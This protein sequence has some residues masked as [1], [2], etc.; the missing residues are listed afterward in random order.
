MAEEI[1]GINTALGELNTYVDGAFKDGIISEAEAKAIKSYLMTL[2]SKKI[3][4]DREYSDLYGNVYINAE[5]IGI[6]ES[7]KDL[8][9]Q[10][11]I[12]LVNA[13]VDSIADGVS[14]IT[15]TTLVKQAFTNYKN[16]LSLL[17]SAL[18]TAIHQ[19]AQA[20]VDESDSELREH[21]AGTIAPISEK[22]TAMET[23]V[24]QT[25]ED[26]TFLATKE[27]VTTQFGLAKSGAVA[28]AKTYADG[29]KADTDADLETLNTALTDI[30]S[31][32]DGAFK[33]GLVTALEASTI[34]AY[35][36]QL[37]TMRATY[38]ARYQQ[39]Y[40][41]TYL[42]TALVKTNLSQSKTDYESK[43]TLLVDSIRNAV[44]DDEVSMEEKS[45]VDNKFLDY[46]NSIKVLALRLED[47]IDDIAKNK[48]LEAEGNAN[49]YTD[50]E[51]VP[52]KET[53]SQHSAEIKVNAEQL[54]LKVSTETYDKG[55]GDL[56]KYTK[57]IKSQI[58]SE[59]AVLEQG[60]L[61]TRNL[62]NTYFAD[63]IVYEAEKKK[64][65]EFL[66]SVA[67]Y[68]LKVDAKYNEVYG[69]IWLLGTQKTNLS[70]SKTNADN[71]HTALATV[72]TDAIADGLAS[73]L[74]A[75]SVGTAFTE[76]SSAI[77]LLSSELIKSVDS[78]TNAKVSDAT[79]TANEYGDGLKAQI[80][81]VKADLDSDLLAVQTYVDT[82]FSDGYITTLESDTLDSYIVTLQASKT[83]YD[84]L[85]AQLYADPDLEG[86]PK[87][88]L[89]SAKS[90]YNTK[91]NT[92][93]SS[94]NSAKTDGAVSTL[95]VVAVDSAFSEY[96]YA[97]ST[98]NTSLDKAI[99]SLT[100]TKSL[101]AQAD[102]ELY[103]D[104]AVDPLATRLR[105]AEASISLLDDEIALRVGEEV[106]SKI[107]ESMQNLNVVGRNL[108]YNSTFM[109]DFEGWTGVT[110]DFTIIYPELESDK[111][112]SRAVSRSASGL[113][114]NANKQIW[115]KPYEVNANG[116]QQ[117]TISFD[118]KV[119]SLAA[120]DTDNVV[121]VVRTFDDPD[122]TSQADSVWFVNIYKSKIVKAGLK[123]NTWMR[124][125][126][127]I[128][129]LAGKY[130]K[131]A[132]YLARNGEVFWK[133]I[134]L[135]AGNK[136][137]AWTP[138]L[139]DTD[140]VIYN[141]EKTVSEAMLKI[142]PESIIGTVISS[143]EYTDSLDGKADA[144]K[145]AG[146]ATTADIETAM[147]DLST[148]IGNN[149]INYNSQLAILASQVTQTAEDYKIAF[150]NGGG[151][152][153]LM[154]SV[155][156]KGTDF[157]TVTGSVN[158]YQ[159]IELDV[160]GSR[161]A[162]ILTGGTLTQQIAVIPGSYILSTVVKKEATGA[163][164]ITVIGADSGTV[165]RDFVA[166]TEYVYEK[167]EIPI[168]TQGN[169]IEIQLYG[170]A[171][172]NII[173]TSTMVNEGLVALKW[174][175]HAT[176][177]YNTNI[178]LDINGIKVISTEYDGYTNIT[179]KEFSGYAR[180]DGEMKRVFTLN[181]DVTEMN[182]VKVEGEINMPPVV[183]RAI[184]T[185]QYKGWAFL[186]SD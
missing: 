65:E 31:Y 122:K 39:I 17:V 134:K 91:F 150:A 88:K 22:V 70:T 176:E 72:I 153:L 75:D 180:V 25:A 119:T 41:N 3:E 147:L 149:D 166:G 137:Y 140:Q 8:Y 109:K 100:L 4:L 148:I 38:D 77:A 105:M 90:S 185:Q 45:D 97:D 183:V 62:I 37:D 138:A 59:V 142:R 94:I 14:D 157:W 107:D 29:L 40:A 124:Y 47:A 154:N 7:A 28:D 133:E 44:L 181:K 73:G 173:F 36:K 127:V 125:S 116:T 101:K 182:R 33:D 66:A 43:Y 145:L 120:M 6:M 165:V 51:L 21:V 136:D 69:N 111:T 1:A 160:R 164:S 74:E 84:E 129:P 151:V 184:N 19:I 118:I 175:N 121:F 60:V 113:V 135:G 158:T 110:T 16:A 98:L 126:T 161:S 170:D 71:K 128:K 46:D 67:S 177:L 78:I 155:G 99:D 35:I 49:D 30:D 24:N 42:K 76:F 131:V 56:E 83:T 58:K 146:L 26:I 55:V 9:D 172:S 139:E 169:I 152:N 13:I 108:V 114:A 68:K 63:G 186:P 61:D 64:V 96:Q 93:I 87:A 168:V 163:G 81:P 48:A 132:P 79:D 102:A 20:K 174:S 112:T 82:S 103:A 141:L 171:T 85:Y 179:P 10:A 159:G 2:E 123:D 27:E 130:I 12:Q 89:D 143:K 32:V 92:V 34:E 115:S 156:F 95:E 80:A 5:S 23:T 104:G 15:E 57:G 178:L 54:L 52:V 11:Y 50:G 167:V 106:N 162:F 117:F 144:D 18:Q 53:I 86:L